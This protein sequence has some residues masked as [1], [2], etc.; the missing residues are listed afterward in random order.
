MFSGY[1]DVAAVTTSPFPLVISTFKDSDVDEKSIRCSLDAG[2]TNSR[3]VV[4]VPLTEFIGAT[5]IRL[6]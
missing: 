3:G 6:V 2:I 1:T 4:L 5:L